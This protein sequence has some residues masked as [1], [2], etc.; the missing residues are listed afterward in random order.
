MALRNCNGLPRRQQ[1]IHRLY[2]RPKVYIDEQDCVCCAFCNDWLAV[3]TLA[4]ILQQRTQVS[5]AAWCRQAASRL[6][7]YAYNMVSVSNC[8]TIRCLLE[9]KLAMST[10]SI[11]QESRRARR[12]SNRP[13]S[14]L[15]VTLF[16]YTK[17]SHF[18][19]IK[20]IR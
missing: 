10:T 4:R 7:A 8:S 9:H 18:G 15:Y 17:Q 5:L 2:T 20:S 16:I 6:K 14:Y 3:C 11:V 13:S 19:P 1:Y 12:L